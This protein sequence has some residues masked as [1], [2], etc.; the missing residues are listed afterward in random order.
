DPA[1][2]AAVL[3]PD[4]MGGDGDP[5]QD[6]AVTTGPFAKGKFKLNV[7]DPIE[8]QKGLLGAEN[9]TPMPDFITRHFGS[10][11]SKQQGLPTP[12]DVTEAIGVPEY[13]TAPYSAQSAESQS[14]RCNLEGWR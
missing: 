5:A 7:L 2:T 11:G 9:V 3:S 14:F 6:Y 4:F 12:Q 13:D 8:V 1:S 10:L